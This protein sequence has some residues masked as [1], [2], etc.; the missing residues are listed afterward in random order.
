MQ[1]MLQKEIKK[2]EC[3]VSNQV[4]LITIYKQWD[5]NFKCQIQLFHVILY[6]ISLYTWFSE[7]DLCGLLNA[8]YT[9]DGWSSNNDSYHVG[10]GYTSIMLRKRWST[11]QCALHA[12]FNITPWGTTYENIICLDCDVPHTT[13]AIPRAREKSMCLHFLHIEYVIRGLLL[14][15][16]QYQITAR[17]SFI[18]PL[19]WYLSL[20]WGSENNDNVS[21]VIW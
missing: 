1:V 17:K 3:N 18:L 8:C 19:G 4:H 2:N 12:D 21:N 5:K 7:S 13:I 11:P 15:Q 14:V 9:M 16:Y 20:C 6:S 10:V